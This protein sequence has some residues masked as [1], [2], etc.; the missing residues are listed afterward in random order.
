MGDAPP[1]TAQN[2]L[3]MKRINMKHAAEAGNQCFRGNPQTS[4]D[5]YRIR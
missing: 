3:G 4:A 1:E 5:T 2:K